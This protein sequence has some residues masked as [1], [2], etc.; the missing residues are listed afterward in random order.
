[1][2]PLFLKRVFRFVRNGTQKA[3]TGYLYVKQSI[4]FF[5]P[6]QRTDFQANLNVC[7][8]YIIPQDCIV[9]VRK[10]VGYLKTWAPTPLQRMCIWLLCNYWVKGPFHFASS[11]S[12]VSFQVIALEQTRHGVRSQQDVYQGL[13]KIAGIRRLPDQRTRRRPIPL[14]SLWSTC[15]NGGSFQSLKLV[16]GSERM[17]DTLDGKSSNGDGFM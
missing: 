13:R 8:Y 12:V 6:S 4:L 9:K 15:W 7:I 2:K 16:V 10:V 5:V 14:L 11:F 1:M 3:N 17:Q